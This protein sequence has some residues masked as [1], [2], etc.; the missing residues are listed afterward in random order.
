MKLSPREV[1]VINLI[2]E[3]ECDECRN[4]KMVYQESNFSMVYDDGHIRFK[5]VCSNCKQEIILDEKYPF[6]TVRYE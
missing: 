3:Y 5:H 1:K 4:G 2:N 6:M